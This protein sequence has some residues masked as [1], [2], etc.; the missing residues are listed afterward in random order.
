MNTIKTLAELYAAL[1]ELLVG[2]SETCS[3]CRDEDCKGYMWLLPQEVD[4]LLETSVSLLEINRRINFINPFLE[5]QLI[6]VEQIKPVCPHC[7][8]RLCTIRQLR[9]LVC[10][11]YPL[12]FANENGNLC[13]VL[14]LDCQFALQHQDDDLFKQRAIDLIGAIDASLFDVIVETFLLVDGITKFPDGPNRYLKIAA[15]QD[16]RTDAKPRKEVPR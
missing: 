7:H 12:N 16:I 3:G 2:I 14:H 9:P 6:N 10:R 8:S 1:D 4:P 5:D 13:F 11:L 15:I